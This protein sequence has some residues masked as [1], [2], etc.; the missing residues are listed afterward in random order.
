MNIV[1]AL[2]VLGIAGG[3]YAYWR[4]H[5]AG[6]ALVRSGSVVNDN[7]FVSLPP[8][9]GQASGNVSVIAAQNCPEL[10]RSCSAT[11]R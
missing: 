3:G 9:E 5:K 10:P 7:G 4:E 8:A 1:Q 6:P 2:L 11:R